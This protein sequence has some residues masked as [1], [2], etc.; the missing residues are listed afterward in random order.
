MMS[1]QKQST[2]WDWLTLEE[3]YKPR[4][5]RKH[6]VEGLLP[7]P[8]LSSFFGEGGSFKTF[9]LLDLGLCVAMGK[10]WLAGS[11]G[12]RKAFACNRSPV[13]WVD[14]DSGQEELIERLSALGRTHGADSNDTPFYF[15][16]FPTPTFYA[17]DSEMVDFLIAEALEVQA[18]LIILDCL[19]PISGVNDENT[20]PMRK[21]MDGL[22]LVS[23]KTGA[24][25][26]VI[27]HTPKDDDILRGHSSIRDA[28]DLALLVKRR[29]DRVAITCNKSRRANPKPFSA[30]FDCKEGQNG[31]L[32]RARFVGLSSTEAM[33]LST[34]NKAAEAEQVILE[35]LKARMNQ[36]QVVEM[37]KDKANIGRSTAIK[38]LKS[39]VKNGKVSEKPG[40]RN[41]RIYELVSDGE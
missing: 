3:A 33:A 30:R 18:K 24:A 40:S 19:L 20:S 27:H 2:G 31:E 7:V 25:V 29:G 41:A 13:L 37:L 4:P 23:I 22:R 10:P 17:T 38:A 39:L 35:N 6:V 21:A 26:V 28:L 32:T 16:S 34:N 14:A 15:V 12:N 9:L 36:S 5:P 1:T 8:S 11:S